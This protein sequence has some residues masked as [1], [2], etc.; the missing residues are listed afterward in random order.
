MCESVFEF[1]TSVCD[2]LFLR[3]SR[4]EKFRDYV[5]EVW[6]KLKERFKESRVGEFLV[7]AW[8]GVKGVFELLGFIMVICGVLQKVGIEIWEIEQLIG[9]IRRL[10]TYLHEPVVQ[11]ILSDAVLLL[12]IAELYFRIDRRLE[13]L[14]QAP[15]VE[16]SSQ[17]K[18]TYLQCTGT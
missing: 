10:I 16:T 3:G 9:L 2:R 11:L 13:R 5:L 17:T 6:K 15:M 8:K 7:R 4:C 14:E 1:F 18:V 12:V